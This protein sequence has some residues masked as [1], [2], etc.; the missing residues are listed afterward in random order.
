MNNEFAM[1]EELYNTDFCFP[2]YKLYDSEHNLDLT[3]KFYIFDCNV[4]SFCCY[5]NKENIYKIIDVAKKY[6]LE[7]L[8]VYKSFDKNK[9]FEFKNESLDK[10][11]KKDNLPNDFPV[12]F[13]FCRNSLLKTDVY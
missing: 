10:L 1:R 7:S 12:F 11:K 5:A 4:G 2:R 13:W 8:F 6:K 9:L 3:Q